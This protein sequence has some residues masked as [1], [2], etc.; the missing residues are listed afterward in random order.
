MYFLIDLTNHTVLATFA[1][2]EEAQPKAEATEQ[3][4]EL[5][6][7]AR[8]HNRYTL[9]Q[10]ASIYNSLPGVVGNAEVKRFS[11]KISAGKRIAAAVAGPVPVPTT[12]Q[13]TPVKKKA[14]AKKRE[15]KTQRTRLNEE[16]TVRVT[17]TA[18]KLRYGKQKD[19]Q[20]GAFI[21]WLT[22]KADTTVGKAL[23]YC[24]SSLGRTRSQAIGMI[25]KLRARKAIVV[26]G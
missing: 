6:A 24:Q 19:G 14:K 5:V 7:V 20:R 10:L 13:E 1:T 22:P 12:N 21:D 26:S 4:H 18:G 16:A 8:V 23:A 3:D 17:A 2:E 25:N 15:P 9:P 11:D